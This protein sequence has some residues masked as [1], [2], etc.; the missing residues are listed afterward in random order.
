MSD[1]GI[2]AIIT[3]GVHGFGDCLIV[4]Y[5][6]PRVHH[7]DSLPVF[8]VTQNLAGL[9]VKLKN[10]ARE[11]LIAY[12]SHWPAPREHNPDHWIYAS[13]EHLPWDAMI[14]CFDA[15]PARVPVTPARRESH[16]EIT[17]RL[18]MPLPSKL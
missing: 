16:A 7:T 2:Y 3:N 11:R 6:V 13:H 15:E 14:P 17:D 8:V 12:P 9:P 18:N 10:G 5:G 4:G 1:R